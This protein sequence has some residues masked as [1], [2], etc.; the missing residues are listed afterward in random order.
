MGWV[1]M[2]KSPRQPML[3]WLKG[4][5]EYEKPAGGRHG[6]ILK[7]VIHLTHAYCAYEVMT[8]DSRIV[9]GL[10]V[11]IKRYPS[12]KYNICL[13][14]VEDNMGPN[15]RDCPV[16]I[17]DMLTP[18]ESEYALRWRADCRAR[19]EL[20]KRLRIT[21]GT[22]LLFEEP[23]EFQNGELVTE[24]VASE[25]RRNLYYSHPFNGY[26]RVGREHI[27]RLFAEGKVKVVV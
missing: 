7:A 11:L 19:A 23:L 2:Y 17:L 26:Y 18:T 16:E 9:F 13:K 1:C 20:R 14:E 5:L 3:E 24:L 21:A 8:P 25:R 10:V 4:E 15:E 6:K 27:L 22:R 12:D